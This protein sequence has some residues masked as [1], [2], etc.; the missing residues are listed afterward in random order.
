[1]GDDRNDHFKQCFHNKHIFD[2]LD[3]I[4]HMNCIIRMNI[5]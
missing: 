4:I 5:S 3:I 2:K 1:M